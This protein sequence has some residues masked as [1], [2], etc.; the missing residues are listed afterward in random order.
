MLASPLL[1]T[2]SRRSKLAGKLTTVTG[3]RQPTGP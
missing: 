1:L 3:Y 2:V